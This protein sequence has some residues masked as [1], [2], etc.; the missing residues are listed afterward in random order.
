[1]D[2]RQ[3]RAPSGEERKEEK[4]TRT[5]VQN[6]IF[7]NNWDSMSNEEKSVAETIFNWMYDNFGLVA[8]EKQADSNIIAAIQLA[9]LDRFGE[10]FSSIMGKTRTRDKVDKRRMIFM[11]LRELS[12]SSDGSLARQLKK[13]RVTSFYYG[14]RVGKDLLEVDKTF[15]ENYEKFREKVLEIYNKTCQES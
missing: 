15:R 11:V 2:G 5:E 12:K 9:A 10:P 3:L 1:M 14:V 13:D 7:G 8:K 6:N 4:M